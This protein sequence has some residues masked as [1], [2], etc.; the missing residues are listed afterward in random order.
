MPVD[1]KLVDQKRLRQ[2]VEKLASWHDRNTSNPGL[3]EAAGWVA[4]QFKSI[5]GLQVETFQYAIHA[6]PRVPED[7]LVPEVIAVLPGETDSRILVGGH[8]DSINMAE[9]G[10]HGRAPGA[11][12][13]GSGVALTLEV[14]RLM[15]TRK[16]R[17]TMVFVGFS[18]EEQGLLGSAALARRARDE[19]WKIDAVLSNDI[20]GNSRSVAGKH[21]DRVRVFSE[22]SERHNSRALAQYAG[23]IADP[24]GRRRDGGG[25][26][27]VF[28]A[29]RFGRGGDHSSF[30]HEG[31]TAIRFVDSVEEYTR[32]HTAFDLPEAMDFHHL[33]EVTMLNLRLAESLADAAEP[34]TDVRLDR[35]QGHDSTVT[36]KGESKGRYVL[37]WRLTTNPT[38]TNF[39]E[40]P[41]T[42]RVT[43]P[44]DK[45]DHI[46]AIG[47]MGGIPVE[48]K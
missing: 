15:S 13:D 27:L 2:T 5:P 12:D 35:R 34:P 33:A 47:A 14:A 11:N 41:A 7:K 36:W 6:G 20:V 46:F 9:A 45:D 29:D 8:M 3:V 31:F 30:N 28:R 40:V 21:D 4:D 22:E 17:H 44:V 43:V 38:W 25:A 24:S 18:G 39:R 10:V 26:E 37:Y 1:P 32:Q 19:K 48:A 16:W 42:G 23:W